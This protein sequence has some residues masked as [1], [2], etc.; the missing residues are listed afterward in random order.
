[1]AHQVALL[2]GHLHPKLG[3]ALEIL[4]GIWR[5]REPAVPYTLP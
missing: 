4:P 5:H 1:L 2:R 3:I